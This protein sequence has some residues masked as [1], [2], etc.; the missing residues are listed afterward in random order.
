VLTNELHRSDIEKDCLEYVTG[1]V[2][3]KFLSKYPSLGEKVG[4]VIG[5]IPLGPNK[6]QKVI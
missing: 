3:R 1:P 2:T 6:C 5:S 4:N